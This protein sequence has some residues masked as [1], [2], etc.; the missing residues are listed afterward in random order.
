MR[1]EKRQENKKGERYLYLSPNQAITPDTPSSSHTSTSRGIKHSLP[2]YFAITMTQMSS[3][4]FSSITYFAYVF[5]YHKFMMLKNLKVYSKQR[6]YYSCRKMI[7]LS[8][9]WQIR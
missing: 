3:L 2:K 5:N 7:L 6:I 9:N 4:H 1:T 8:K